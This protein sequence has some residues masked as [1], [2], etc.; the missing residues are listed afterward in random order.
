MGEQMFTMKSEVVNW[1]SVV[2]EDLVQSVDQK[3]VKDGASQFQN[4]YVN[5]HKFHALFS[6]RLSHLGKAVTSF[7]QDRFRKC[8]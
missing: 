2:S 8:S 3:F 6:V 4:F 7:A 5:F 1:P